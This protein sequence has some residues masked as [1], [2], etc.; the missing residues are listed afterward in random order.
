[1]SRDLVKVWSSQPET[2]VQEDHQEVQK[3]S[4]MVA[5]AQVN[6]SLSTLTSF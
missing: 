4:E 5:V 2:R 6:P 3:D 1:M